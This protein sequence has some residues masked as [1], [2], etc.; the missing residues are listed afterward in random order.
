M[1][2][3]ENGRRKEKE[4]QDLRVQASE[5]IDLKQ[6]IQETEKK[7]EGLEKLVREALSQI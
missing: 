3:E 1:F 2:L 7:L 5:N 4:I 6:R